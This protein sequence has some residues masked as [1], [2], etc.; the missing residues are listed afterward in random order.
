MCCSFGAWN[1]A[2]RKL[3][4][5]DQ[6]TPDQTATDQV[7]LSSARARARLLHIDLDRAVRPSALCQREDAAIVIVVRVQRP[8]VEHVEERAE[9][10]WRSRP[11]RVFWRLLDEALPAS[12]AQR[13]AVRVLSSQCPRSSCTTAA[14]A[15]SHARTWM[16]STD[17]EQE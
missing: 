17:R 16:S 15:L 6:S 1:A 5:C 13:L 12:W 14:V 4:W 10:D 7:A 2:P 11:G 8:A 9:R 3:A